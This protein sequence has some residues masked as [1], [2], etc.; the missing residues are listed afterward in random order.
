[1]KRVTAAYDPSVFEVGSLKQAK[2]IILTPEGIGT[3]ERWE[4]ETP[5]LSDL[6]VDK[7]GITAEHTVLD[8]GCG[9]GRVA[10]TLIER[11]GCRVIGVDISRTMRVLA[12]LYVD[13]PRFRVL[14][15]G[16]AIPKVDLALS[17]WVLQHAVKP[18]EDIG[19]IRNAL[20]PL[21]RLFVLNN[22]LRAV[23]ARLKNSKDW[24]SDTEDLPALLKEGFV[25]LSRGEL[26]R[27]L[28]PA[29]GPEATWWATYEVA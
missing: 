8:Y 17:V 16:E 19:R 15:E 27:E 23:P 24:I 26:P 14:E 6:I 20:K 18:A 7:L 10:R 5:W 11:T 22:H 2:E 1:M 29:P 4:R 13:S 21:G 25:E 3:E 28:A 12:P 9:V